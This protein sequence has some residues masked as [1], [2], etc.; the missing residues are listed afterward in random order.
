MKLWF[1]NGDDKNRYIG[2]FPTEETATQAIQSFCDER[3][4]KIPYW[5]FYE[6]NGTRIYDVGSWS[7]FF[8]LELPTN[9]A[10][11][12]NGE[13][14]GETGCESCKIKPPTI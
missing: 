1:N 10:M 5:R 7:E 6:A 8:K 14:A 3:Q 11:E 13:T 12:T 2:D 9:A 4:Y